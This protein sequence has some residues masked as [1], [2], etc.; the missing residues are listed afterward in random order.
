MFRRVKFTGRLGHEMHLN[1]TIKAPGQLLFKQKLNRCFLYYDCCFHNIFLKIISLSRLQVPA[2]YTC[3]L[4]QF[5][6]A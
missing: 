3:F 5:R 4:L 6:Q 1:Q 2:V